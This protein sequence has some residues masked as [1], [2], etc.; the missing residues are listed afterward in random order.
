MNRASQFITSFIAFVIGIAGILLHLATTY[1]IYTRHGILL[2]FIGFDLPLL[3]EI[4][5]VCRTTSEVGFLNTYNLMVLGTFALIAVN[6]LIAFVIAVF[7]NE[8]ETP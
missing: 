2:A 3:S 7:R 8:D 5:M 6:L 1:M 4:Y